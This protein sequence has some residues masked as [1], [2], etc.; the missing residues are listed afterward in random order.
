MQLRHAA[1]DT[2][3]CILYY[4]FVDGIDR[5]IVAHMYI[6][7]YLSLSVYVSL[8]IFGLVLQLEQGRAL[9]RATLQSVAF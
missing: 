3:T 9:A 2:I 4:I 1:T 7:H 6:L 8:N 5:C